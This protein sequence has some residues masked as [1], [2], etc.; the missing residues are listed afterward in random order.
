MLDLTKEE[1]YAL[2]LVFLKTQ[3][4]P[5]QY[6][7]SHHVN[8]KKVGVSTA[9]FRASLVS[10]GPFPTPR[11][12]AAFRFIMANNRWYH[13]LHQHHEGLLRS[14]ASLNISSYDLFIVQKGLECAICPWLYPTSDFSDTG[15]ALYHY[16]H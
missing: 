11:A 9:R 3:V 10:A 12:A 16:Y 5:V 15:R 14:G 6:G 7:A 2:T 13:A 1:R 4:K 8:Y